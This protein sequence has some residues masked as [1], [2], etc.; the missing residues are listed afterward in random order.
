MQYTASSQINHQ[1][2]HSPRLLL[3]HSHYSRN[4]NAW[5]A[6]AQ[7]D[8]IAGCSPAAC[9][10][11]L[12]LQ[13]CIACSSNQS[14]SGNALQMKL[15]TASTQARPSRAA[16]SWL[17]LLQQCMAGGQFKRPQRL[18]L[19]CCSSMAAM[20]AAMHCMQ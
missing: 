3:I 7:S 20:A 2:I 10:W 18:P 13:R 9:L 5:H 17:S 14:A 16:H 6:V 8:L 19:T 11:L 15:R 1:A 12:W 4:N